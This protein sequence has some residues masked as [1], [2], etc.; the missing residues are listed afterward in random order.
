MLDDSIFDGMV[1]HEFDRLVVGYSG[2][3]DSLVLLHLACTRFGAGRVHAFHV[4]HG[5]QS[6]GDAWQAHCEQ[7]AGLL[8]IGFSA[9]RVEVR[10][11]G[12]LEEN[13][14]DARYAA[15][16]DFLQ[17]GDLLLLAQHADDQVETLLLS[18]FRGS[19]GPLPGGMPRARKVGSAF[20]YRPLLAVT[21]QQIEA[22]AVSR[23]LKWVLDDSNLNLDFNRNYLRHSVLPV[24]EA[25]WPDV[26]ETLLATLDRARDLQALVDSV[27]ASD[28]MVVQDTGGFLIDQLQA[29]PAGRRKNL[30]RY[31]LTKL[32]LPGPRDVLLDSELE[33]F[34]SAGPDATP[35]LHWQGVYLR[36]YAGKLYLTGEVPPCVEEF[37]TTLDPGTWLAPGTGELVAEA[38]QAPGLGQSAH[39]YLVRTR[40]GG[41][42]IRPRLAGRNRSLGNVFQETGVPPWLRDN[43]P[44]VFDQDLL[45]AVPALPAFGV[46]M[47]VAESHQADPGIKISFSLKNQPYSN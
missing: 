33:R 24:I 10:R 46:P 35:Q 21:R 26:R 15:F 38:G 20:L 29:L 30:L 23:G 8:G 6:A 2:G 45:V 47:L 41:E 39:E 1:D 13:A 14:R 27:A 17:Q 42:K 11:T 43:I 16:G 12:S 3:V 32:G 9:V 19:G 22:Y 5:L 18:L 44:L 40:R 25:R 37:R 4:N 36:R 7:T 31:Q 34:L 28:L